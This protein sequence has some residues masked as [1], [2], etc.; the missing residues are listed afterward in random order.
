M[1]KL[2]LKLTGLFIS[3]Q[4]ALRQ[5]MGSLSQKNII[6]ENLASLPL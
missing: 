5:N 4:P 2:K 1:E 6:Y 3:D